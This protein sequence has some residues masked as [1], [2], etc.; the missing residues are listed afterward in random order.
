MVDVL[1]MDGV[2]VHG[3]FT[4]GITGSASIDLCRDMKG[5]NAVALSYSYRLGQEFSDPKG[6]SDIMLLITAGVGAHST[7]T[8]ADD[9]HQVAGVSERV[10]GSVDVVSG[11]WIWADGYSGLSVGAG[12]GVPEGHYMQDNAVIPF[13]W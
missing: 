2:E 12:L 6:N 3:S 13:E 4:T 11:D 1:R 8:T 5:N 9:V 10:G 7:F